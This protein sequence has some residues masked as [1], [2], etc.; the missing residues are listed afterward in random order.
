M[1]HSLLSSH[2]SL[3]TPHYL[4]LILFYFILHVSLL[5]VPN[6]TLY[7]FTSYS[8]FSLSTAHSIFCTTHSSSFVWQGHITAASD[9]VRDSRER[10]KMVGIW[11]G[12]DE[13]IIHRREKEAS[14]VSI[15]KE[16]IPLHH[17]WTSTSTSHPTHQ[18]Q[19]VGFPRIE[20]SVNP[21]ADWSTD[22]DPVKRGFN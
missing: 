21:S 19:S 4:I 5:T 20:P 3:F 1:S 6:F 15:S 18:N 14:Q 13:R 17:L 11:P 10:K 12:F 2:S 7:W 9:L 22:G 16:K 8:N